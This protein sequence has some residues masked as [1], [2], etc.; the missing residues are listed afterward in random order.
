MIERGIIDNSWLSL[1]F[2][3]LAARLGMICILVK[4]WVHIFSSSFGSAVDERTGNDLYNV[5]WLS[6]RFIYLAAG[7][8]CLAQQ[9]KRAKRAVSFGGWLKVALYSVV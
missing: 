3:H 6:L 8:A 9:C 7:L 5:Y 2:V 4:S 1:G